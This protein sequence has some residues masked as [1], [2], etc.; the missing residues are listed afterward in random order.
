VANLEKKALNAMA[1]PIQS[2]DGWY[3]KLESG[4]HSGNG[5][6]A[7]DLNLPGETDNGKIVAAAMTGTIPTGGVNVADGTVTIVTTVDGKVLRVATL[8]MDNVLSGFTNMT[9]EGYDA[10]IKRLGLVTKYAADLQIKRPNGWSDT[11][12]L[13]AALLSIPAAADELATTTAQID[14]VQQAINALIA[15]GLSVAQ[16][17][18]IGT[19]GN[20]G[21]SDGTHVHIDAQLDGTPLNLFGWANEYLSE[22][23]RTVAAVSLGGTVLD[24][25]YNSS[26]RTLVSDSQ[27]IALI[28]RDKVDAS[29]NLILDVNNRRI[30]ENI[31]VAWEDGV[32]L[33]QMKRIAYKAIDAA[34]H[35]GWVR[36]N[37]DGSIYLEGGFIKHWSPNSPNNLW[38]DI[39]L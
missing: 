34:G 1:F 5:I 11:K 15:N 31:A 21:H 6:Y 17:V 13:V 36:V 14:A 23:H 30:G 33:E 8:H 7:L 20:E 35:M 2:S 19:A 10:A 39:S 18:Q 25:H 26:A 22:A 29:G 9:Y 3:Y 24:L 12:D 38:Q 27:K 28:R 32:P 16:G 37:S 4:W